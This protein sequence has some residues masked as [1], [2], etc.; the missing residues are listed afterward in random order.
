MRTRS[1]ARLMLLDAMEPLLI[2]L[3]VSIHGGVQDAR[4]GLK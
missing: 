3:L 2:R 4:E 1:T